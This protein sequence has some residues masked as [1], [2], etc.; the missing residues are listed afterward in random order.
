MALPDSIMLIDYMLKK[1][2]Y[3]MANL[4]IKKKNMLRNLEC[5]GGLIYSQRLLLALVGKGLTRE[6]AYKIVQSDALAAREGGRRFID[7]VAEDPAVTKQL[8]FEEL[9][10]VFSLDYYLRNIKTIYQ[11]LGI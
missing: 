3:L 11:R 8:N 1:M 5:T 9:H 4:V 7:V 10:E 6:K 2:D